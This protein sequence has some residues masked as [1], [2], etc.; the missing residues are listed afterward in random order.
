[1]AVSLSIE[2]SSCD[3]S[4]DVLEVAPVMKAYPLP[5]NNSWRPK[6]LFMVLF[7]FGASACEK[8]F[9]PHTEHRELMAL[10]HFATA[11]CRYE[12]ESGSSME[13]LSAEDMMLALTG[14]RSLLPHQFYDF[15]GSGR[16]IGFK[17]GGSVS[18]GKKVC[19]FFAPERLVVAIVEPTEG[20]DGPEQ[21]TKLALK[22]RTPYRTGRSPNQ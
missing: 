18:R 13:G 15:S 20:P 9:G 5:H 8:K 1:M 12:E 22:Q 2:D 4:G 10:E 19:V 16:G 14:K 11:I 21:V 6:V 17:D 7:L 3:G